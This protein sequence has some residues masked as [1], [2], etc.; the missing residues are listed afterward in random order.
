MRKGRENGLKC[1]NAVYRRIGRLGFGGIVTTTQPNNNTIMTTIKGDNNIVIIVTIIINY[2]YFIIA[3]TVM[4]L[5]CHLI[6]LCKRLV[7]EGNRPQKNI[8]ENKV[9]CKIIFF[10][11]DF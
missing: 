11:I 4:I 7:K 9:F 8:S 2:L 6:T 5:Y 1:L 10:H 3:T